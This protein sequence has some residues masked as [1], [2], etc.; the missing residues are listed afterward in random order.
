MGNLFGSSS[1]SAPR[2]EDVR[3]RPQ[4]PDGL[5]DWIPDLVEGIGNQDLVLLRDAKTNKLYEGKATSTRG[6][7]HLESPA[8]TIGSFPPPEDATIQFQANDWAQPKQASVRFRRL[9]PA[10]DPRPKL[11]EQIRAEVQNQYGTGASV[12][13]AVSMQQAYETFQIS[14]P[15]ADRES[16]RKRVVKSPCERQLRAAW[17]RYADPGSAVVR[18]SWTPLVAAESPTITD[19]NEGN[20]IT[21]VSARSPTSSGTAT[22]PAFQTPPYPQTLRPIWT[23]RG[24][25]PNLEVY[26]GK[27][28]FTPRALS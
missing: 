6:E 18:A 13:P 22:Y 23:V 24:K 20:P 9:K 15:E 26:A 10:R 12:S 8:T 2:Y 28:Y 25:S 4:S 11:M 7:A 16:A 19:E 3:A 27:P 5:V 17:K 1:K 14:C 21:F